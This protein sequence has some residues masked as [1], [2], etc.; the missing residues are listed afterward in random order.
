MDYKGNKITDRDKAI[1]AGHYNFSK[2]E[3]VEIK[4][5]QKSMLKEY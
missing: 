1:I 3:F 2:P 5:K 4:N